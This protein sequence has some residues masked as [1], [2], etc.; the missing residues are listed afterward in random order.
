[1]LMPDEVLAEKKKLMGSYIYACQMMLNPVAEDNQ[2]FRQEWLRYHDGR[3]S[4]RLNKY[5]V[6]DPAGQKGAKSDY[7]VMWVFGIDSNYN[8]YILDCV[9]DKLSLSERWLALKGLVEKHSPIMNVGYEKYGMQGDIEYMK[10]NME[11]EGFY[12]SIDKLGGFD[13]KERRIK[14][15]QPRF[16]AGEIIIPK[17][18]V[19]IDQK[20]NKVNITDEFIKTEYLFFPYSSHD[21]MLDCMARMLDPELGVVAPTGTKNR[22]DMSQ[23]E[24]IFTRM[25]RNRHTGSPT[26]WMV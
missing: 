8:Y 24:T 19:Y 4:A 22:L 23:N 26:A 7:T 18:L 14:T 3:V 13:H 20:G 10:E 16:Q 2:V 15:L 21:D 17:A 5:I 1:V 25:D 9:R 11:R 6:V 12:F